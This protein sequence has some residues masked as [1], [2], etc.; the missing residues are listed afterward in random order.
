MGITP[1]AVGQRIRALEDYLGSDLLLRGR[2]GLAPTAVLELA[3]A[4]LTLA[5][6]ALNRVT[7]TLDFQ[8]VSEIHIVADPD[9][10]ELW[11]LPRL[12]TFRRDH[13][14]I[15]FCINGT[16]DIPLRLGAPDLRVTYGPEPGDILLRDVIVPATGPDNSRRM[17]AWDPDLPM[18][19]MPLLHLRSQK[20]S[21]EHP[22]W[23]AWFKTF[24]GRKEGPGRGVVSPNA[25][26]GI[27][28]IRKDVGFL[29]CGL[30][31]LM[32]DLE[33]RAVV[34]PFPPVEHLV[35]PHPY[36]LWVR[37]DGAGRPQIRKFVAWL[38]GEAT[39]TERK[40]KEMTG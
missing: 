28:A 2:S 4:D 33:N 14:R 1:A 5:F 26:V 19:G 20:E 34:L 12:P 22:G 40:I 24:G 25:R 9:W 11:L 31:L 36:R 35:A 27:E 18:E 21:P 29:V 10:A 30:S 7:D 32:H 8:R 13:P 23:E 15:L 16:G 38:R 17:A 37:P 6:D 39:E 3:M